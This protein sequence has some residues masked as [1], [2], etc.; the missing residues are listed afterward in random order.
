MTGVDLSVY[1]NLRVCFE[2]DPEDHYYFV[3]CRRVASCRPSSLYLIHSK[4]GASY[5]S[6]Q[7]CDID[8]RSHL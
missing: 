8:L 2:T 5:R 7:L 3:T 6:R 1:L 4:T